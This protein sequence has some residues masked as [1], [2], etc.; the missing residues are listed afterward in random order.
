MP[1]LGGHPVLLWREKPL[2][3]RRE[4]EYSLTLRTIYFN[5]ALRVAIDRFQCIHVLQVLFV[6]ANSIDDFYITIMI[7]VNQPARKPA[8]S[9]HVE[10][11]VRYL[12]LRA[13]RDLCESA[14]CG[15]IDIS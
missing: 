2:R 11:H 4:L 14:I 10:V 13:V 1:F 12:C 9:I 7:V 6:S 8:A 15:S 3:S 5:A